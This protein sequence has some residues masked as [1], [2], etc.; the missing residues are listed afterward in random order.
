MQQI[1]C[2]AVVCANCVELSVAFNKL[3]VCACYLPLSEHAKRALCFMYKSLNELCLYEDLVCFVWESVPVSRSSL[4]VVIC[5][6][7][8]MMKN[9]NFKIITV[10]GKGYMLLPVT[11]VA[12]S[13]KGRRI[14]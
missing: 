2:P 3:D 11:N 9:L 7:R 14:I 6:L 8:K 13:C 1:L 12:P 4:P 5:E 10:R